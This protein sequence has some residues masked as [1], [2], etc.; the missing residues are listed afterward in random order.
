[1]IDET[2]YQR[3]PG[4]R[5]RRG[6]GGV[7]VRWEN[8]RLL[9]ALVRGDGLP[10]YLLP[11]GGVEAG[12]TDEVAARR[13]IEEEAG[14]TKLILL[15]DLGARERLSYARTR[16][17]VTRYFLFLAP[18]TA[19]IPTDTTH[20]YIVEWHPIDRLPAMFWPEQRELIEQNAGRISTAAAA[21]G[22]KA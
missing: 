8:D 12:E 11:K 2:W 7:V 14:L 19:G 17:Q 15:D 5:E 6:A 18:D 16:W 1:M 4:I 9:V 10:D 22:R 3:P 21:E 20:D 13:E